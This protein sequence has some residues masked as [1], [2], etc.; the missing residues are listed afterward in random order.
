MYEEVF[1]GLDIRLTDDIVFA[2]AGRITLCRFR[3]M[4]LFSKQLS[5]LDALIQK[6]CLKI[7]KIYYFRGDLAD[8]SAEN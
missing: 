4:L 2:G 6:I 1:S 7:M 8:I 3:P 5:F